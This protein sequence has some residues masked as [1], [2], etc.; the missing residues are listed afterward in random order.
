MGFEPMIPAAEQAKTVHA[1][2]HG[3]PGKTLTLTIFFFVSSYMDVSLNIIVKRI[4]LLH[5]IH[6]VQV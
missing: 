1:L 6:E 4:T 2:D 5:H 3:R